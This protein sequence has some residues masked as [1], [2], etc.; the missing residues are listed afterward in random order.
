MMAQEFITGI[1]QNSVLAKKFKN[2]PSKGAQDVTV[3]LPFVDDFSN[4]TGYPNSGLWINRKCFANNTFAVNPPTLG[5][6]TFD[7]LDENGRVYAHADRNTF[8]ADT[9]TSVCI[10]LDSNFTQHRTMRISD[11][12]YFSFYYQPGGGC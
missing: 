6:V 12:I 7:A 1:T 8:A 4:Y 5:V 10:R 11:S 9:L 2:T 3:R